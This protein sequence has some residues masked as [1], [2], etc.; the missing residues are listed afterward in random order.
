M[1]R[2]GSGRIGLRQSLTGDWKSKE[3]PPVC[4]RRQFPI[5]IRLSSLEKG[6]TTL[7]KL[8]FFVELAAM[9]GIEFRDAWFLSSSLSKKKMRR[10]IISMIG[11]LAVVLAYNAFRP[12]DKPTTMT[13]Q[14]TMAEEKAGNKG[15]NN[16]SQFCASKGQRSGLGGG[17]CHCRRILSSVGRVGTSTERVQG[18]RRPASRRFTRS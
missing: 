2:I 8:I 9:I 5:R 7:D 16:F 4:L 1:R 10:I 12:N 6:R 17:S 14:E 11:L 3:R 18:Q 15:K 13:S